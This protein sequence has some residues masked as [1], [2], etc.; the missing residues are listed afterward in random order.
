MATE[1]TTN[2][3]R[4]ALRGGNG[5][6]QAPVRTQDDGGPPLALIAVGLIAAGVGLWAWSV[7]EPDLRRYIKMSSM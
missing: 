1:T 2:G 5:R 3:L 4:S 6:S 7:L